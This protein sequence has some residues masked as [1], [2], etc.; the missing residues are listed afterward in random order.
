MKTLHP[1]LEAASMVQ[2]DSIVGRFCTPYEFPETDAD[3]G[4]FSEARELFFPFEGR[5]LA[6]YS[7]GE[8]RTVLLVHGWGSRASHLVLLV[9]TLAKAGFCAVAFD[10]PSHGKSRIKDGPNRSNMFEFC[11]AVSAVGQCASPLFGVVGHSFGAATAAFTVAGLKL[12]ADA[13]IPAERLALI[14]PPSGV[15]GMVAHFCRRMGEEK[16]LAELREGLERDYHFSIADY[17]LSAALKDTRA[18]LLIVHDEEDDEVPVSDALA[19]KQACPGARLVLTRGSGHQRILGNR[20]ML[21]AVKDFLSA[22]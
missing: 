21:R 11:R 12:L 13:K 7:M 19:L 16:R 20:T 10:G 4:A 8:G 15:E 6:G 9:K 2:E 17:S 1:V 18:R 3:R 14:S 5:N 22:P